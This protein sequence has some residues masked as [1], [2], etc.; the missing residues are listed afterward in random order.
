MEQDEEFGMKKDERIT[1]NIRSYPHVVD[2]EFLISMSQ[3]ENDQGQTELPRIILT[4][5]TD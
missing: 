2:Q 4:K 3:R 1:Q 5:K